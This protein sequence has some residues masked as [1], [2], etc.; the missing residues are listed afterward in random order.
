MKTILSPL[1]LSL[2]LLS[3]KDV[4]WLIFIK[5]LGTIFAF[6]GAI[7]AVFNQIYITKGKII[8]N[9]GGSFVK[10]FKSFFKG[11]KDI[12]VNIKKKR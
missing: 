7:L 4:Q 1:F 8:K 6:I 5:N 2:Y 11:Y 9:H 3:V 10:W 12:G